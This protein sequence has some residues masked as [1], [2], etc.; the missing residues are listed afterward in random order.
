VQLEHYQFFFDTLATMSMNVVLERDGHDQ[1]WGFRLQGGSD[2]GLPLSVQRVLVGTPAEVVLKR[3]D[4][5]TKI[6]TTSTAGL[7]HQQ[8]CDLFGC[9]GNQLTVTVKR[10]GTAGAPASTTSSSSTVSAS[11][12]ATAALRQQQLQQQAADPNQSPQVAALPRTT[13]VLK[14]EAPTVSSTPAAAEGKDSLSVT[15]QP[16]RTLPLVQPSVKVLNE[17]GV[18]S[19]SHLKHQEEICTGVREPQF[20]P[21]TPAQAKA[22]QANDLLM[23][24][25]TQQGLVNAASDHQ[26]TTVTKTTTTT[27]GPIPGPTPLKL[28]GS[29]SPVP[30][31]AKYNS[32]SASANT[33]SGY[34]KKSPA[35]AAG[36]T[37]MINPV[38]KPHKH[39]PFFGLAKK[40][41]PEQ[42]ATWQA[43]H[44]Q[45]NCQLVTEHGPTQAKVYSI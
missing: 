19:Y 42:S 31:P 40:Y 3:G 35:P 5:V 41:D 4:L 39:L 27:T 32:A 22:I 33:S 30:Q 14:S 20:V 21:V 12:Q 45:E 36:G 25:K 38:N 10:V 37:G 1:P 44:E 9:G 26:K 6:G 17:L 23:K 29:P 43:I 34:L 2:V 18:G 16:Y 8:A 7:S 28:P 24:Q 15:N 11:L 13:F